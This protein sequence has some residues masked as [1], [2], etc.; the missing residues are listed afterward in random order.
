MPALK[1]NNNKWK[2]GET[3]S[4]KYD[5]QQEAEE[6]NKDYME[7][8]EN[9]EMTNLNRAGY[10]NAVD[11]IDEG[12]INVDSDWDFTSADSNELLG[13][14]DWANY[15]R[16]FLAYDDEKDQETK[17]RY[18]YPFGKN[19]EVYRKALIAI[20]QYSGRFNL[21]AI[22]NAAGRLLEMIDGEENSEKKEE[23]KSLSKNRIKIWDNKYNNSMEKR[24]FNIE[25]TV[26]KREDGQE[27]VVGYASI[28]DSKSE[29]LGG[30]YEYIDRGAF[31]DDLINK[32]DV[33]ALINHDPNLILA[34]NTSGTLELKADEKGLRYEF[35]IPETSYG[36]DLAVNMR[37]GNLSQSSF[38]F[39]VKEDEWSTD[40]NG[41]DI[42]T[43][44]EIDSLHDISVV[45]YPAYRQAESDLV[46]AQRGLAIYKEKQKNK[47]EENDLVMRSLA[48]LKIELAKRK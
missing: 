31:N 6:D 29:N 13:D 40:D 2:W 48:K 23:V 26:E 34:R 38:A 17:G 8:N 1:C 32:S 30:F 10:D 16:W 45:T 25:S 21:E 47:E 46:I 7:M 28:Y 15:E 44:K 43:I 37:N 9:R 24:I 41:N 22:F 18:G 4:C 3:G 42:R 12:K 27:V 20:R 35:S 19:G 33:R 39:I 14:D 36:K 11:L 5:S